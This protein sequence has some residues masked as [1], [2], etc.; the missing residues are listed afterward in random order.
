M[1]RKIPIKVKLTARG[2][3][4]VRR[5]IRVQQ[6]VQVHSSTQAWLAAWQGPLPEQVTNYYGDVTTVSG[7][8]HQVAIGVQGS[9]TQISGPPPIDTEQF[10]GAAQQVLDL[11]DQLPVSDEDREA[12]RED[13][14]DVLDVAAETEPDQDRLRARGRS[15]LE[16]LGR[17]TTAAAGGT[18]AQ[19]LGQA[20]LASVT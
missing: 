20:I 9:V 7:Q 8:G 15:M 11:L 1:P 13:A 12:L 10:A 18:I 4:R 19:L 16:V 2:T 17:V 5:Q 3:T 6:R 14:E